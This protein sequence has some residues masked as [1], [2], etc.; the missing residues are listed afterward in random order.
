MSLS[1]SYYNPDETCMKAAE[2]YSIDPDDNLYNMATTIN[3]QQKIGKTKLN[4]HNQAAP[5]FNA[6]GKYD[7]IDNNYKTH[8]DSH[9]LNK[10]NN[11]NNYHEYSGVTNDYDLKSNIS[12]SKSL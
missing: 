3:D 7:Y 1:Y 11:Y 2:S 4:S 9:H 10:N 5:F 8:A 12:S 6:Q